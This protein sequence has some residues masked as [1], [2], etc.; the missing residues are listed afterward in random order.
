MSL[1]NEAHLGS[2]G[3]IMPNRKKVRVYS[4]LPRD[5]FGEPWSVVAEIRPLVIAEN[6]GADASTKSLARD[7]IFQRVDLK[8]RQL[9]EGDVIQKGTGSN[10]TYWMIDAVSVEQMDQRYRCTTTATIDPNF[11]E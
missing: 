3:S 7:F 4:R 6:R 8:N 2:R 1:M 11:T 10:P 9:S 5:L